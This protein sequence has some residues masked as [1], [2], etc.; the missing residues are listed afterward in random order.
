MNLYC[1]KLKGTVEGWREGGS[2]KARKVL[3]NWCFSGERFSFN[4]AS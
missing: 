3:G 2:L 4:R 1:I